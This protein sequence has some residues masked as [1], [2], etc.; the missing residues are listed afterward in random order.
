MTLSLISLLVNAIGKVL[1]FL[2][3]EDFV[4]HKP[5]SKS[6]LESNVNSSTF[7]PLSLQTNTYLHT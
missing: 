2:P 3:R 6:S 1:L 5:W 7:L 4:Q